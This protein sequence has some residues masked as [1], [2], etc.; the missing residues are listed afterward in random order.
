[1]TGIIFEPFVEGSGD[2]DSIALACSLVAPKIKVFG[3]MDDVISG[4]VGRSILSALVSG[5]P[6]TTDFEIRTPSLRAFGVADADVSGGLAAA[7][8]PAV[9]VSGTMVGVTPSATV[10]YSVV[11]RI[12]VS[13]VITVGHMLSASL[14]LPMASM[15]SADSGSH[16]RTKLPATDMFGA[17][18]PPPSSYIN[19]AQP[20][21]F[22]GISSGAP[23]ISDYA[24]D[25]LV[26]HDQAL[27]RVYWTF[28]S[29]LM[30]AGVAGTVLTGGNTVSSNVAFNDAAS[31]ILY[32]IA[33]SAL[34]LAD[35]P[36][37]AFHGVLEAASQLQLLDSS[38]DTVAATL[39]ASSMLVM[40]SEGALGQ[41]L[42]DS[43]SSAV[44]F[45]DTLAA[46]ARAIASATSALVLADS[47]T[48]TLV[49]VGITADNVTF[50][51]ALNGILSGDLS[52]L[53][54]L[55]F[56][57]LL[58]IT[59]DPYAVYSVSL[60]TQAVSEYTRYDYNSY[61]VVDDVAY[62]MG[63]E[64][65]FELDGESDNGVNIDARF[66]VGL[67][68]MGTASKKRVPAV[69]LGYSSSGALALRVISTASPNAEKR[70]NTYELRPVAKNAMTDGRVEPSKG[71]N[72]VYYQFE[73]AN[74]DGSTFEF[75]NARVWR[76]VTSRRK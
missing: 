6:P 24:S 21:G 43:A 14:V 75:D 37:I 73:L 40:V 69:Y 29:N 17:S 54:T 19:A 74:V 23:T 4:G 57:G 26:L 16:A 22:A 49:A 18:T 28:A 2:P 20:S 11:P 35:T 66:R 8:V 42:E 51:D 12:T 59:G 50:E 7:P 13:G 72:S 64:G 58:R 67:S 25:T 47:P 9:R 60:G 45:T 46:Q 39:I 34:V 62:G 68:Q 32:I 70:V 63:A 48:D 44:V 71:L 36:S 27:D 31:G 55:S 15:F 38:L 3:V 53:D 52:L 65:I 10:G 30:L 56:T 76:M 33:S 61:C 5:A 1:M 41:L